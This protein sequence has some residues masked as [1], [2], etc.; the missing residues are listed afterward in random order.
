MNIFSLVLLLLFSFSVFAQNT[1]EN[2][3]QSV[4]K[5]LE[6]LT[7]RSSLTRAEVQ[8]AFQLQNMKSE[9]EFRRKYFKKT[10]TKEKVSPSGVKLPLTVEVPM[11][12]VRHPNYKLHKL[13]NEL[14]E[15]LS[16][17]VSTKKV[18]EDKPKVSIE[19]VRKIARE[20]ANTCSDMG[21]FCG[22]EGI[23]PSCYKDP[24]KCCDQKPEGSAVKK[25][26]F[27]LIVEHLSDE[28]KKTE[29]K[30]GTSKGGTCSDM[31]CF[32]GQSNIPP[33]CYKD[34]Y[35]CC[36]GEAPVKKTELE[37]LS[38][39]LSGCKRYDGAIS[40]LDG[41]YIKKSDDPNTIYQ[42]MDHVDGG[43]ETKDPEYTDEND[44]R[45]DGSR[46][47]TK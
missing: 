28:R 37:K 1:Y 35:R 40:C 2:Q 42:L 29:S 20:Y 44:G 25:D 15:V 33:A 46:G 11:A 18:K 16:A 32:C 12:T 4:S 13:V 14:Q 17:P 21:C 38:D 19:A 30:S 23:P 8:R 22:K 26:P 31:G 45:F 47:I 6:T 39:E 43:S 24:Y 10:A 9:L 36:L 34:P 5:E 41:T 27:A 3:Y 7:S